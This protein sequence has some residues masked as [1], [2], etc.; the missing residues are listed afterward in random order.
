MLD[1][2]RLHIKETG[3]KVI[4]YD[5][6]LNDTIGWACVTNTESW[7]IKVTGRPAHEIVGDPDFYGDVQ[8]LVGHR[9]Y[10][11]EALSNNNADV[12]F[13]GVSL[14]QRFAMRRILSRDLDP[15]RARRVTED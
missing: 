9:K 12:D 14:K 6:P 5:D 11:T 15:A 1:D 13:P 4:M 2:I 3:N 8:T 10:M 7:Q